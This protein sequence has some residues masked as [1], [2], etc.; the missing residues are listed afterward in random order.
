MERH[1]DP[2]ILWTL[3]PGVTVLKSVS[4]AGRSSATIAEN[5]RTFDAT[6]PM[7]HNAL[8]A[9]P[10]PTVLFDAL[11]QR[12]TYPIRGHTDLLLR[13]GPMLPLLH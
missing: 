8:T 6:A 3:E 10:E 9:A 1:R 12:P 4:S 5:P 2:S 7:P 11:H 13:R